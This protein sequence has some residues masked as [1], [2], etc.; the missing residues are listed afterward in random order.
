VGVV[1]LRPFVVR[2]GGLGMAKEGLV[3]LDMV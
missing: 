2:E 1:L 3:S